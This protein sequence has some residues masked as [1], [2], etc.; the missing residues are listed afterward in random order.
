MIGRLIRL[1][2]VALVLL[3]AWRIGEAYVA[4][5]KFADEVD[6]I[7]QTGVRSNEEDIRGAVA[8]AAKMLTIPVDPEAI[9]VRLQGEHVYI[10]LRYTRPIEVAPRYMY[11]WKFS[12]SAHGWIVASG[13]AGKKR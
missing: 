5:Y 2:I 13:G 10:D 1:A 12:V 6:Q 8:D 3:G 9:S 4:H 11:D 7:A